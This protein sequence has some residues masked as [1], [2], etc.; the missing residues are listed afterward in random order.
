MKKRRM[1]HA[2]AGLLGLVRVA[3]FGWR[4]VATNDP[5]LASLPHVPV[6]AMDATSF[7]FIN[8]PFVRGS[9][10]I[11]GTVVETRMCGIL[12]QRF[13]IMPEST[14]T[15]MNLTLLTARPTTPPLYYVFQRD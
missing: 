1:V 7:C 4:L 2:L 11:N 5:M 10:K 9:I 14:S 6:V 15:T 8:A 13:Q 12:R 3:A